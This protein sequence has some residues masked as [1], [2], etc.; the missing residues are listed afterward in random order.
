MDRMLQPHSATLQ[1]RRVAAA[2]PI[3]V[4]L[5]VGDRLHD[6]TKRSAAS[7]AVSLPSSAPGNDRLRRRLR[8][9]AG[10]APLSRWLG[11]TAIRAAG[12]SSC[13]RSCHCSS[14]GQSAVYEFRLFQDMPV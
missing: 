13:C 7:S 4:Q 12:N 2:L 11:I 3:S 10:I 9:F 14:S 6:L 1:A 5:R 8:G